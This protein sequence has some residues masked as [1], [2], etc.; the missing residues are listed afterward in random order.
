[1]SVAHASGTLSVEQQNALVKQ[2]CATCHSDRGKAGGLTLASFDASAVVDRAVET[3]KIIRK[4]RAGMMPPAGARRPEPAVI[5]AMATTLERTIDKA[6]AANPNPGHRPF[7]R[8][9]RAEYTYAIRDLLG[10]DVD[11]D[12]YL[13][14]DTI[15]DGLDKGSAYA[16]RNLPYLAAQA[17]AFG[18]PADAALAS[19]TLVPAQLHGVGGVLGSIETGKDASLFAATGDILDI[20]SQV[21]QLWISG[22]EQSL[23]TRHTRLAERYRAR[24]Q[25]K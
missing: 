23:E 25:A 8:M 13:P 9:N 11:V 21:K 20:R 24:P 5:D 18:L 4:L 10:L 6:A 16:Q 22:V 2:Y 15:S 19:I 12:A 14:P 17:A 3:E 1:M 7:Q